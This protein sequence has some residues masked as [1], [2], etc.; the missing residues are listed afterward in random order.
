MLSTTD[1]GQQ[2]PTDFR[3]K[4]P[5]SKRGTWVPPQVVA[6]HNTPRSYLVRVMGGR[7]LRR[8]RSQINRAAEMWRI[9][10][11]ATTSKTTERK[12]TPGIENKSKQT[13]DQIAK[14]ALNNTESITLQKT[15]KD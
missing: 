4:R 11:P 12:C 2:Y 9:S 15:P 10:E 3:R 14:D 8:N 13:L 7:I 1:P 5:H 6:H